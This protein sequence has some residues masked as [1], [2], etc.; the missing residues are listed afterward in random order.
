MVQVYCQ[1]EGSENAPKNPRLCGFARVSIPAG[2]S[3]EAEILIPQ[4]RFL[5][6]DENGKQMEEGCPVLYIGMGQPDEK[7]ASLTGRQAVKLVL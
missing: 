3:V 2:A 7:T 5:V 1:N 4:E 6:V